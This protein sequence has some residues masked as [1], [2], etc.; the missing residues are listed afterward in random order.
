LESNFF[1]HITQTNAARILHYR[2]IQNKLVRRIKGNEPWIESASFFLFSRPVSASIPLPLTVK[3]PFHRRERFAAV[4]RL[5][6]SDSVDSVSGFDS[7]SHVLV[8][9]SEFAFWRWD[10]SKLNVVELTSLA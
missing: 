9:A 6:R 10:E 5:C 1:T 2:P 3:L 4:W 7:A 8:P